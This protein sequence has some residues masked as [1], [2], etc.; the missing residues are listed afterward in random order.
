MSVPN[1]Y[2]VTTLYDAAGAVAGYSV[3]PPGSAPV[4]VTGWTASS[5]PGTAFTA[6]QSVLINAVEVSRQNAEFG[7]VVDQNGNVFSTDTGSQVKYAAILAYVTLNPGYSGT[8]NTV[9]NGTVTLNAAGVSI[10][11]AI[12][13]TYVQYCFEWQASVH[14][15]INAATT[16]AQLQ[17]VDITTGLPEGALPS[18]W[19]SGIVASGGARGSG[20]LTATNIMSS[21]SVVA[22]K[23]QGNSS[24]PPTLVG[25]TGAGTAGNV[26]LTTG[27]SDCAGQIN[28]SAAGTVTGTTATVIAT[29][30]F[31]TAYTTMPF[32]SLTAANMAA[33]NLTNLPYI[34]TTT[35]GFQLSVSNNCALTSGSTF[36]F[37]YHVVQ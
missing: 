26:G 17:A 28:V 24:S 32:V 7:G 6:L 15:S 35:T 4:Q 37:N 14:A 16:V 36:A 3:N 19:L 10:L 11:C 5:G 27:S 33:G 23:F 8:W 25:G 21:G 29:L 34:E 22:L 1:N 20:G 12:V 9:N 18:T 2:T 31:G 30:T 13:L